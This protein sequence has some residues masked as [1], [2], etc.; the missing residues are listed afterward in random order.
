MST[1]VNSVM[2]DWILLNSTSVSSVSLSM[3]E[4]KWQNLCVQH[5]MLMS[6]IGNQRE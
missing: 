2:Y 4:Q 5:R 3:D 1:T 6:V